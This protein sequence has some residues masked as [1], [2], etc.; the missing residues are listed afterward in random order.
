VDKYDV[1]S[2]DRWSCGAAPLGNDLV[3]LVE[4]RTKVPIRV[5]YGMTETTCL[6]SVATRDV[7]KQGSVGKLIPN[8]L[9]KL[10]DGELFVQGPNIMKGYL[11]NPKADAET[12]TDDGWMRTGDVCR[13]DEDGNIFVVDRVKEVSP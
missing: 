2:L 13:F 8:M 1:S 7:T 6:I 12:F 4:R 9:A 11:R 5:G 10:V 3:D